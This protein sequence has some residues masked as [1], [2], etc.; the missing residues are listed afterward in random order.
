M[1]ARGADDPT[2]M[3]SPSRADPAVAS[4]ATVPAGSTTRTAGSATRSR[5]RAAG[6]VRRS[7]GAPAPSARSPP[8]A[9]AAPPSR[10]ATGAAPCSAR[11]PR[12]APRARRSRARSRCSG[13]SPAPI[14]KTGRPSSVSHH[15]P[16]GPS[17]AAPSSDLQLDQPAEHAHGESHRLAVRERARLPHAERDGRRRCA[18]TRGAM[19]PGRPHAAPDR[20]GLPHAP[21]RRTA[22][23]AS[24]PAAPCRRAPRP[25]RPVSPARPRTAPRP[26]PACGPC[27]VR[28]PPLFP[29]CAPSCAHPSA[30]R[31]RRERPVTRDRCTTRVAAHC[32]GQS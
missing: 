1:R 2:T 27:G 9:A 24:P 5:V 30:I 29:C 26:P 6:A 3:R 4:R 14:T 18:R 20:R 32:A 15:R 31:P 21:I 19:R 8:P 28:R 11:G 17:S 13:G 22:T 7:P 23:P 16:A 25:H 10:C 12:S